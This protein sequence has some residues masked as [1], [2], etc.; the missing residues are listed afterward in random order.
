MDLFKGN[1]QTALP[2]S[3][4][5]VDVPLDRKV[6]FGERIQVTLPRM[7]DMISNISVSFELPELVKPPKEFDSPTPGNTRIHVWRPLVEGDYDMDHYI[8]YVTFDPLD[9]LQG[10]SV[11]PQPE[12]WWRILEYDYKADGTKE[13]N[14]T[15]YLSYCDSVSRALV[16]EVQLIV[17]GQVIQTLN[18]EI[19][20]LLEDLDTPFSQDTAMQKTQGRRYNA[21]GLGPASSAPQSTYFSD[22]PPMDMEPYPRRFYA[23]LK[24][25]FKGNPQLS[26]PLF[27]LNFHEVELAIKFRP[28]TSV[29]SLESTSLDISTGLRLFVDYVTLGEQEK[30]KII[31]SPLEYIIPQFQLN[32]YQLANTGDEQNFRMTFKHPAKELLCVIQDMTDI[33]PYPGQYPPK[34][35]DYQD[36]L[37]SLSIRLNDWEKVSHDIATGHHLHSIVPMNHHT[38]SPRRNQYVVA[39]TLTPEKEDA[40]GSINFSRVIHPT[41]GIKLKAENLVQG[42]QY[43]MRVYA[44]SLN[45]FIIGKGLGSLYFS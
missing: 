10:L 25:F 4:E 9:P 5:T 17:G 35:F 30:S 31:A 6:V 40:A 26:L 13:A 12:E 19:M 2:F 29:S 16:E 11:T 45:M 28:I 18:G 36:V 21:E 1:F 37:G 43:H 38:A 41:I 24:F 42:A 34:L 23:P 33:D 44:V 7:G 27:A 3:K 39:F 22:N 20:E 32:T 14:N 15:K 8:E